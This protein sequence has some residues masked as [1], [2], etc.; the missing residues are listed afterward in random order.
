MSGKAPSEGRATARSEV[1]ASELGGRGADTTTGTDPADT[2]ADLIRCSE[3]ASVGVNLGA[4]GMRTSQAV[5]F[6]YDR[7]A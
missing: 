5:D 2:G 7:S 3:G 6:G 4:S 1:R